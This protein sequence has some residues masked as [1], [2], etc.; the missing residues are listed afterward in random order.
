MFWRREPTTE[1]ERREAERIKRMSIYLAI[2]LW[3]FAALFLCFMAYYFFAP[4][5]VAYR[6]HGGEVLRAQVEALPPYNTEQLLQLSVDSL[7]G[8]KLTADYSR[9][10]ECASIFDYY[11]QLAP[12]HGWTFIQT[13]YSGYASDHYAGVFEGYR[14]DLVLACDPNTSEY[15]LYVSSSSQLCFWYCPAEPTDGTRTNLPSGAPFGSA[16]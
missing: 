3:A 8:L 7:D 6:R 4:W 2:P 11:R 1:L 5:E 16:Q 13:D 14:A 12:A 9:T 10:E 15:G